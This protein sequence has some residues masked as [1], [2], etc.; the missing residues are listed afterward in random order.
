MNGGG[1][2]YRGKIFVLGLVIDIPTLAPFFARVPV[3]MLS[4][5]TNSRG[6]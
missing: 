5:F 1:R 3:L 2:G 6:T 4:N